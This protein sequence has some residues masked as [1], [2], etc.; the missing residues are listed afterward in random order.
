MLL[1][2][3]SPLAADDANDTGIDLTCMQSVASDL[4]S[5][6]NRSVRNQ[7]ASE[8]RAGPVGQQHLDN[9]ALSHL[10]H[11]QTREYN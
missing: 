1:L 3:M 5:L 9:S 6:H 8:Q 4:R 10:K 11:F 7:R 2:P